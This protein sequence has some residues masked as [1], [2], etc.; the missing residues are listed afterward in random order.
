MFRPIYLAVV[1]AGASGS[2]MAQSDLMTIYQEALVNSAD[3]AAAEADALA[4]QEILPQAKAQLLPNIGVRA[5]AARERMDGEGA[6]SDG[7]ST[8]YSLAGLTHPVCRPDR[9]FNYQA[10]KSQSGQARVELS[11]N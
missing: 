10:A 11:A 7:Y 4:R 5:R 1:L 9:C 3:L 8:P 2:A 6:G